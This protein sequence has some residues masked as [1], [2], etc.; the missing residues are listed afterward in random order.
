MGENLATMLTSL[1]SVFTAVLGHIGT[2][3][4]TIIST[5]MLFVPFA[6]SIVCSIVFMAKKFI[7]RH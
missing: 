1:G 5:P 2:V 7:M 6:L 4:E 3:G